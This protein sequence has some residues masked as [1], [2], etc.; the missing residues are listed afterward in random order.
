MNS[1]PQAEIRRVTD[2]DADY[3]KSLRE[4]AD[5]PKVLYIKGKWPLP[6]TC[7]FGIVGSRR[8]TPYGLEAA[9]RFTTDLVRQGVVTVS[10]LAAGIDACAHR[11]TLAEGG[12][13]VAILGHGFEYVYPKENRILFK[14]IAEKGTIM[15]EFPYETPPMAQNFPQRNRIISG[16]SR[17]V[18]VVEAAEHSGALITARYA[19]EQG[20][21]VFVVPGSIFSLQSAGCHRL[22]K[23]G[24]RL[25]ETTEDLLAEYGC[26]ARPAGSE[27]RAAAPSDELLTPMEKTLLELL[28]CIPVSVDELAE[29]SGISV[30]RLAEGLL[31]LELKGK[32]QAMPGQLYLRYD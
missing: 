19:G 1:E 29:A 25:V 23:E 27:R 2:E 15:T 6:E 20:K 17:G 14:Q 9:K 16:L 18:L 32:I 13:T 4:L 3:P 8:A 22:I 30:D 26:Q 7:L 5:R 28:S 10:G 12:W 11:V 31:S 21:D 24:A